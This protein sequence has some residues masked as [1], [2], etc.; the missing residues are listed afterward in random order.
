MR[1]A[2]WVLWV[3]A[4][5]VATAAEGQGFG[6]G[7][8]EEGAG[9]ERTCENYHVKRKCE[10]GKACSCPPNKVLDT[11]TNKCVR[12]RKCKNLLNK[13]CPNNLKWKTCATCQPVCQSTTNDKCVASPKCGIEPKGLS[14]DGAGCAC[15]KGMYLDAE[16][17]KCVKMNKCAPLENKAALSSTEKYYT[18]FECR[19]SCTMT[20]DNYSDLVCIGKC[21]F[22]A[23]YDCIPGHVR[24]T[25]TGE[26]VLPEQCTRRGAKASARAKASC[27]DTF[28][29]Y[30]AK[31]CRSA[32]TPT[33]QDPNPMCIAMCINKRGCACPPG[34][35]LREDK[36]CVDV[37]E[38]SSRNPGA[39]ECPDTFQMWY[40]GQCRPSVDATCE[41]P[42]MMA[43]CRDEP[44]CGCPA[45]KV[46]RSDNK[47]VSLDECNQK[48][49]EF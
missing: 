48:N 6:L 26:C 25:K 39:A 27:P 21:K 45:G 37:T 23:G 30:K 34:K 4:V 1:V 9:C 40:S 31:T 18:A 24:N 35:V 29:L 2:A 14:V 13:R 7:V 28:K 38:C 15:G 33:C 47:C 46:L 8:V 17:E 41:E 10:C 5:V 22:E 42:F 32:C 12:P 49:G 16:R 3:A 43:M 20:C 19:P 36:K 11:E 44:G